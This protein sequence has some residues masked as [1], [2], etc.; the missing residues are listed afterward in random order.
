MTLF[1]VGV[2]KQYLREHVHYKT[3]F[4]RVFRGNTAILKLFSPE[5][6]YKFFIKE[7]YD[8]VVSYLEGNPARIISG[9][10]DKNCKK[11]CW[12]H[13]EMDTKELLSK[14]FR[15]FEEAVNCYRS[16]DGII[17]VSETVKTAFTKSSGINDK[18]CVKYNTNETNLI[19]ERANETVEDITFSNEEINICSV[20]K[21]V[22]TKGYDRLINVH[23]RLIAEGIR[24]HIYIVGVGED[25]DK[26]ERVVKENGLEDSFTFVGFRDNPY[27]YIAKCD[28]YVCSS[29]REGFSTAVTEALVLGVPV[30]STCCSGAYELL[31]YNN[32]YGIVTEN[33]ENG[34]YE[35]MYKMLTTEGLLEYYKKQAGIRGK[36][37]DRDITVK[38][39]EEIL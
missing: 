13:I 1:D 32:E 10:N 22:M 26:L 31:G 34:I 33:S 20:A 8:T 35:G 24:E 7:R 12:I 27:K 18:L 5:T 30:V 25:K 37:F 39:V 14:A 17:C 23:K 19:K 4:R 21:V 11:L 2:N 38:S 3:I 6:L 36:A 9:C 29:R 28:L 16:F 15:N